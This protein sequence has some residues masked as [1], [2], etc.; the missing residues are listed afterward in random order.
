MLRRSLVLL[1]SFPLFAC[2]S[3]P[4]RTAPGPEV[5]LDTYTYE[6]RVPAAPEGAAET[7]LTLHLP[8]TLR[9]L[10][11]H[12]L[13]GNAAFE[14]PVKDREKSSFTSE[15]VFVSL[16]STRELQ[17]TTPGRPVELALRMSLPSGSPEAGEIEK[18]LVASTSAS[19]DGRP[20]EALATR[21]GPVK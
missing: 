10:S 4:A 12:G 1:V 21:F 8:D 15:H 11:I 9:V 5:A 18:A 3:S 19:A 16:D 20:L 17:L 14:L 6:I 7:R 13:V 2:A